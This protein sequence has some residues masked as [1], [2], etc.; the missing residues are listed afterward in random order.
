MTA[1]SEY[2]RLEAIG[3]WRADPQAQRRDV[4]LSLGDASL[5]ISDAKAGSALA[6]WSLPA[7]IRCN[8]G[9]RPA[10]YAPSDE[11]GETVE[12]DDEVMIA[13]IEKVHTIIES[14]R[15][16]PGRLRS[17]L[18]GGVVVCVGA[19]ALFWLPGA[20]VDHAAR[21]TP[22]A[23]RVEIGR[24]LLTELSK[25]AGQPCSGPSGDQALAALSKR[26]PGH[27][28][29]VVLPEALMGARLLPG[30][31]AVIGRN[32]IEGPDTPEVV[33]GYLIATEDAAA[34]Q[35]PLKRMLGD[36]GPSA[37]LR[38]LT[39]GNLPDSGITTYAEQLLRQEPTPP[40]TDGLLRAFRSAGVSS[41]PFAYA[42]DPTGETVL[43]LIEAD[44][45]KGQPSPRPV[46]ADAQWVA[47]QDICTG[48]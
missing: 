14:H 6:H 25:M 15:P 1:L 13:A 45:F 21:I 31:L 16:H 28:T 42:L 12:L 36:L 29:I 3:L 9:E 8:P 18:I 24:K 43:G 5:V 2:E 37:A 10:I 26:L 40:P 19:V 39:T 44:P 11:P 23:K 34:G 48:R 38:L 32:A 46:L 35:S 41:T 20:L 22:Q 33:A 47:L 30:K 4:I 17:F 27:D 7:M